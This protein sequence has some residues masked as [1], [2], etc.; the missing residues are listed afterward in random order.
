MKVD[1]LKT[2]MSQSGIRVWKIPL[3]PFKLAASDIFSRN[4]YTFMFVGCIFVSFS[5]DDINMFQFIAAN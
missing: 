4:D 3:F 1:T 5:S 2:W